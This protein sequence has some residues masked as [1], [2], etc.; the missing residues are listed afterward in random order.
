[1]SKGSGRPRQLRTPQSTVDLVWNF[2]LEGKSQ[3]E[4]ASLC[5]IHHSTV[6]RIFKGYEH[7]EK[8]RIHTLQMKIRMTPAERNNLRERASEA[9][10]TIQ[11]YVHALLFTTE[12]VT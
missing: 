2:L 11:A 3:R 12:K 9:G 6:A 10:I 8:G 4:T 1:M 7:N 5:S